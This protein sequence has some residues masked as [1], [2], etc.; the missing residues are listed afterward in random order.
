MSCP[1]ALLEGPLGELLDATDIASLLCVH[2][3]VAAEGAG[4]L[5]WGRQLQKRISKMLKGEADTGAPRRKP[6]SAPCG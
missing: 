3:L 4:L 1:E 5:I 2:R 6:P